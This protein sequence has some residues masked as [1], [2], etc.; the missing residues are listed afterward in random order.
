M[1]ARIVWASTASS[2]RR[3]QQQ[4]GARTQPAR[5]SRS[6]VL[7]RAQ[8]RGSIRGIHGAITLIDTRAQLL[9]DDPDSIGIPLTGRRPGGRLRPQRRASSSLPHSCGHTPFLQPRPPGRICDSLQQ[10]APAGASSLSHPDVQRPPMCRLQNYPAPETPRDASP[11]V[12]V[13]KTAIV[14]FMTNSRC[15]AC[16][17]CPPVKKL[18][19]SSLY[20]WKW[21]LYWT[22]VQ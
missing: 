14:L 4:H 1:S 2:A 7:H 17:V 9:P 18:A 11:S 22:L 13:M 15:C 12:A 19:G 6:H 8:N 21:M 20:A 5:I 3:K 10:P 16:V